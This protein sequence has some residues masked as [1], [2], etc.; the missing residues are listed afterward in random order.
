MAVAIKETVEHM[1]HIRNMT[2]EREAEKTL[3]EAKDRYENLFYS[4]LLAIMVHREEEVVSVNDAMIQLLGATEGQLVGKSLYNFFS[5]EQVPDIKK[6]LKAVKDRKTAPKPQLTQL[7]MFNALGKELFL[8]VTSTLIQ[9]NGKTLFQ[10]VA[11]DITEQ[12]KAQESLQYMAFHDML[13]GL[14]NRS[15]FS[16]IVEKS[17]DSAA[18]SGK[19]LYFLFLD[20]DRFKQVNDTFG[21]YAGDQLML[22]V[23]ERMKSCLRNQDVLSRFGGDEFLVLLHDRTDEEVKKSANQ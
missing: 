20:L 2:Q 6:G 17:I 22:Q 9:I 3:I 7:K 10:T 4:S 19:K 1:L 5:S 8:E 23:V 21:H 16:N 12:K 15:M 11:R 18:A 13:T 14:P